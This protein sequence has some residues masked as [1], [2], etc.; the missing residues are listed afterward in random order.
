[1]AFTVTSSRRRLA[2]AVLLFLAASGGVI[3]KFAP[4]P[5]VMRDIGTLLL[6]LWLPAVGNFVGYLMR[7]IPRK[8]PPTTD[9]AAS[10]VFAPQ[11]QVQVEGVAL[12]ADLVEILDPTAK[13]CTVLVGR[14][15]FTVRMAHPVVQAFAVAGPQTMAL[16]LLHPKVGLPKLKAGTEIHLL[17]GTTGVAKGYVVA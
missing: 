1:M 16:E 13:L 12:P 4:D 9:F 7:K 11:L 10:T 8:P 14:Q 3:R 15:G 2:M 5:S 6:V 17:V